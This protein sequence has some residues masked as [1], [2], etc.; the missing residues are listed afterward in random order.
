MELYSLDFSHQ[1]RKNPTTNNTSPDLQKLGRTNDNGELPLLNNTSALLGSLASKLVERVIK[2][3]PTKLKT[4][5][6]IGR[7]TYFLIT[8][9]SIF[10]SFANIHGEWVIY[11]AESR[12]SSK[13][14]EWL[15]GTSL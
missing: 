6:I 15:L 10:N 2:T 3:A 14:L 5:A 7:I 1:L 4:G 8:S 11:L 9:H 12:T 13:G